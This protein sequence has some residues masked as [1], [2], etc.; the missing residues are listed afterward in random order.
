MYLSA[1]GVYLSAQGGYLSAQGADG[2][3]GL[4]ALLP[5][6]ERRGFVL[7]DPPYEER[8]DHAR[9]LAA[10]ADS[11]QRFE[12]ATLLVWL[13]VKMRG[14]FDGWLATRRA[15]TSRPVLASLL[16]MHPCD[17]RAALNGSALAL[18]NPPYLVEDAMREWLPE[19]R[20]LLGGPQSGCEVLSAS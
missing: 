14:D 2:F 6:P 12:S 4:R 5:P 18:V 13:P 15:A 9:V 10:V 7:I 19:L 16:W 20:E 8:E 11:L 1:Q 3:A 17:S